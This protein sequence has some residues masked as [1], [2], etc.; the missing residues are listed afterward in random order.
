MERNQWAY[1]A[2]NLMLLGIAVAYIVCLITE[3]LPP[4]PANFLLSL[5]FITMVLLTRAWGWL[6]GVYK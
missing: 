1:L 6:I 5:W 4:Y 3:T 2:L